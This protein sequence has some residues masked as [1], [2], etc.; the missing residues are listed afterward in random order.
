MSEE[1]TLTRREALQGIVGTA[2][3]AAVQ[4]RAYPE[5]TGKGKSVHWPEKVLAAS[6]TNEFLENWRFHR[7]D[8]S[9]AEQENFDDSG[10]RLLDVPHDWSIEDVPQGSDL[11]SEAIWT[12]GATPLRTGAVRSV[13]ERG[14]DSHGM[15]CGWGRLVSKTAHA[16]NGIASWSESRTP[17]RRSLHEL[18]RMG[19]QHSSW[20]AP[21][22]IYRIRIRSG[23]VPEGWTEHDCRAS[24]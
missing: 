17:V 13:S 19:K 12:D 9:N 16:A 2:V 18:R 6:R 10:W 23:T 11:A 20:Q 1:Y 3:A 8:V 21:I 7:G 15:D 4:T 22:W 24:R 14:P 5:H